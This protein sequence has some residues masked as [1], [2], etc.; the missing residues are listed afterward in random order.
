MRTIA[1]EQVSHD[2]AR[3]A[4]DADLR[5][6]AAQPPQEDPAAHPTSP[7]EPL[8]DATLHWLAAL[9]QHAGA[10][11][12]AEHFPR[13]ANRLAACWARPKEALFYLNELLVDTRCSRQGF[14]EAVMM[15]L[16]H[17]H[18]LCTAAL[19]PRNPFLPNDPWL[20]GED[21]FDRNTDHR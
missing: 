4:L 12:L 1:F 3:A 18:D 9:P 15:E 5:R 19:P 8:A 10:R 16:L 7:P 2:A 11:R 20:A 17:L 6:N 13:I 21:P 14:P